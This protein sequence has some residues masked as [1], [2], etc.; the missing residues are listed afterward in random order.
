MAVLQQVQLH[1]SH[2]I[3]LGACNVHL[4]TKPTWCC[5][6][7]ECTVGFMIHDDLAAF[8]LM[9]SSDLIEHDSMG[10]NEPN[11]RNLVVNIGLMEKCW[12]ALRIQKVL[13]QV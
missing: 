7:C 10:A 5:K 6:R 8:V 9:L 11:L 13:K 12:G 4:S 1:I 2:T 3:C